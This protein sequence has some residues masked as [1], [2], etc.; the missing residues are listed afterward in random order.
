MTTSSCP[1][2]TGWAESMGLQLPLRLALGGLF[3][4]AAVSKLQD[5]QTFAE[6]I[7]AFQVVD[8][9]RLGHLVAT[10]TFVIP[11]VELVAGVMLIL[12]LWTRAASLTIGLAL[13]AFIAG[14]VSVIAR[15]LDA[16]CSC[17]GNLNLFC[18]KAV[19]ACQVIRNSL[20]LL[21]AFYLAWRGSG[22]LGLDALACRK[23]PVGLDD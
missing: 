4:L 22:R 19:G 21:P 13:V 1:H 11:W 20:M 2:P 10:A 9:V 12:G 23:G 14:L 5:P 17:F 18:G 16:S 7:K 6:A 3:C 15:G 8:H